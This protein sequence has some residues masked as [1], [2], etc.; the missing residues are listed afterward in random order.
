MEHKGKYR[1]YNQF[2]TVS[3]ILA[4]ILISCKGTLHVDGYKAFSLPE[5]TKSNTGPYLIKTS[6]LDLIDSLKTE[7]AVLAGEFEKL[8]TGADSLLNATFE[9]VPDNLHIP[10]SGDPHDYMSLHRYSYPDSTGVYSIQKDGKTNPDFYEYDKPKLEKISSAIYTFSLAY[11]Y[12]KDEKYAAKASLELQNWF[13]EPE[14]RMNPNMKYSSIRPGVNESEGGSGIVGA[15]DFIAIIEGASLLYDSDSWTPDL[16]FQ[17]KKWFFEFYNW[18]YYHYPTDAYEQSNISTWLDLQ[19]GV[20][21]SFLEK[22]EELNSESHIQPVTQRIQSQIEANGILPYE[23]SRG[24]SQGYV[25][26]NLKAYMNLSLLRKNQFERTGNDRDWPVLRDC[27]MGK[28]DYGGLNMTLK[29]LTSFV[30]E[31]TQVNLF[32]VDKNFNRCRYLEVFRPAA[33][34][35]EDIEY[36]HVVQ[37]LLAEGCRNSYILL[38]YPSSEEL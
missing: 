32:S 26:F 5:F 1:F 12:T 23:K 37:Q 25:F 17:L 28:C 36:E 9:Y 13:F 24:T 19:R 4:L 22:E 38:T 18:M 11:Y 14:T 15:L 21:L 35:F 3:I 34:V 10:P 30:L 16:H 6:Q 31:G 7:D 20:Y 29:N 27:A 2:I 8:I 33:L